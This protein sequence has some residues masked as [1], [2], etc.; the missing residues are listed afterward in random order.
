MKLRSYFR[1]LMAAGAVLATS[2]SV[3]TA[4]A[5]IIGLGWNLAA[6]NDVTFYAALVGHDINALSDVGKTGPNAGYGGLYVDGVFQEFSS[7]ILDTSSVTGLDGAIFNSFF[8]G[9]ALP[10][11]TLSYNFGTTDWLAMTVSGLGS[12]S[13]DLTSVWYDSDGAPGSAPGLTA[14]WLPEFFPIGGQGAHETITQT[15]NIAPLPGGNTS[16]PDSGSTLILLGGVLATLAFA[17]R[18]V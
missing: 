16:V 9:F 4:S 13:H 10:P 15:I 17:R 12:G 2:A 18:K 14:W 11:G 5:H 7:K 6:N 8:A 1:G 3:N